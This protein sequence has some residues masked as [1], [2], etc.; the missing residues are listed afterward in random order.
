MFHAPPAPSSSLHSTAGPHDVRRPLSGTPPLLFFRFLS[1]PAFLRYLLLK[2]E[3]HF[4]CRPI[5]QALRIQIAATDQSLTRTHPG[6]PPRYKTRFVFIGISFWFS[7]SFLHPLLSRRLGH[8]GDCLAFQNCG[9]SLI[10]AIVPKSCP[11]AVIMQRFRRF[12]HRG[13]FGMR[14]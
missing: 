3:A 7:D 11:I 4:H 6:P 10:N 13:G 2:F 1:F 8:L 14:G 12:E 9:G 5:P